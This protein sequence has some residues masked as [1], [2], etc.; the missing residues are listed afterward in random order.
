MSPIKRQHRL[1]EA[2]L[3][4]ED[5]QERLS[6]VQERVRTR[7]P[8]SPEQRTERHRVR[9]CVTKVWLTTRVDGERFW[10][11]V[12]SESQMVRGLAALF[13]DCYT[14]STT[15]E[16]LAFS[17]TVLVDSGLEKRITPTRLHGLAQVEAAIRNTAREGV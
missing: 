15:E 12:D 2:L 1:V 8:L 14:G 9:G 13:V 5:P 6:F 10:F 7:R 4:F 16:I 11:E 17:C 3:R